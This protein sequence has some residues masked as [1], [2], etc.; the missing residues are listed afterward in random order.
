M[1]RNEL[2][3]V[4]CFFG[5]FRLRLGLSTRPE[6]STERCGRRAE[7]GRCCHPCAVTLAGGQWGSPRGVGGLHT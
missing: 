5:V 3:D 2:P 6:K 7:H 4:N 1:A